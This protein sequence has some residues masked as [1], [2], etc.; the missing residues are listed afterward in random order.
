MRR[1]R[2][3]ELDVKSDN[4]LQLLS[5]NRLRGR[6]KVADFGLSIIV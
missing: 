3:L 4:I 5:E 6:G 1:N 2:F